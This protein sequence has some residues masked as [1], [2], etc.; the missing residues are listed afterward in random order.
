MQQHSVL[1][2]NSAIKSE[3]TRKL[4]IMYVNGFKDH[5]IIKSFDDLI[6]IEPKKIQEM[7][8]NFVMYQ[9]QQ[10]LRKDVILIH[11]LET[12]HIAN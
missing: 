12:C 7:L 8:E 9:N 10:G 6:T 1:L 2:F 4:Y 11:G 5:F 3:K